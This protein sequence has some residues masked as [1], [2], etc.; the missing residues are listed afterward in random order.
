MRTS[1]A[2]GSAVA[3]IRARVA[4]SVVGESAVGRGRPFLI[5]S[6]YV[7]TAPPPAASVGSC[8]AL[9]DELRYGFCPGTECGTSLSSRVAISTTAWQGQSQ[10]REGSARKFNSK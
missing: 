5:H 3:P 8:A 9:R 1:P 10:L 7:V 6:G 4:P 2:G